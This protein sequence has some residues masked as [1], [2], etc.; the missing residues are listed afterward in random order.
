[1]V[2]TMLILWR[3]DSDGLPSVL[4]AV[5]LSASRARSSE[6]HESRGGRSD[7]ARSV[8]CR[9]MRADGGQEYAEATA[10]NMSIAVS[11]GVDVAALVIAALHRA[12][13]SGKERSD[14]ERCLRTA[15]RVLSQGMKFDT[16]VLELPLRLILRTRGEQRRRV[17]QGRV[18]RHARHNA[19][20]KCCRAILPRLF[21][22]QQRHFATSRLAIEICHA[23]AGGFVN[24]VARRTTAQKARMESRTTSRLIPAH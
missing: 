9:L 10:T 7:Q 15:Q 11:V 23:A 21:R 12:Q 13:E 8:E 3:S 1:M 5:E 17:D 16:D 19:G 2:L 4:S 18:S 22:V 6:P 20:P 24:V 14:H